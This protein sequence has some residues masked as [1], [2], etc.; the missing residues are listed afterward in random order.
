MLLYKRNQF[1]LMVKTEQLKAIALPW[2]I[3]KK[4]NTYKLLEGVS[5]LLFLFNVFP[6]YRKDSL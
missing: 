2:E 5:L 3:G 4:K 1:S 6:L